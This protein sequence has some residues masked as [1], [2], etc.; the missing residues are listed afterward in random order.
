ML[1]MAVCNSLLAGMVPSWLKV[2]LP[3]LLAWFSVLTR[4]NGTLLVVGRCCRSAGC[5]APTQL[6]SL[7]PSLWS[8][9]R[10]Q[11]SSSLQLSNNQLPP[12][13]QQPSHHCT[14]A[15]SATPITGGADPE[16]STA[17]LLRLALFSLATTMKFHR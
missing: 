16:L 13:S 6:V 9:S 2:E 3:E 5:T 7:V 15:G 10:L 12:S 4:C 1:M 17:C 11:L 14:I 8:S